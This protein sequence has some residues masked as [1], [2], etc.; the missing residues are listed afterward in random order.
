VRVLAVDDDPDTLLFVHASVTHLGHE[1]TTVASADEAR[2]V[3]TTERP[4]V[5]L[6]DLALPGTDGPRLLR[7][8]RSAG[9][10]PGRVLLIS[11]LAPERLVEAARELDVPWL[12]KPFTADELHVRL[13][14]LLAQ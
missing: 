2:R 6:L 13:R 5:L 4:D 11:A 10:A 9:E 1:C 12:A 7:D 8:L 3:C 14:R